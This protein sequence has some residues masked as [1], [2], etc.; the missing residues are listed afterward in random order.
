VNELAPVIDKLA[1]KLGVTAT[2]LWGVLLK[3][4]PVAAYTMTVEYIATALV[5]YLCWRYRAALGGAFMKGINEHEA[6]AAITLIATFVIGIVAVVWLI[7]CLFSFEGF[8]TAWINPEYWALDKI[9][10][11]VKSK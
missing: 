8:V 9:I 10:S 11:S 5:L 3:Q 7:S 4:A 2:Y 6:T 1:A